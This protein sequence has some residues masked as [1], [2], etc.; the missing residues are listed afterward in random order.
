MMRKSPAEILNN[1]FGFDSFLGLQNEIID[2]VIAG[3]DAL[4][5]MPTGG[6]KSLC[7]QIPALCRDG[8]GL[9]ISPLLALM[10]DQVESLNQLGVRASVLNSTPAYGELKATEQDR[11]SVA[12]GKSVDRGGRRIMKKNREYERDAGP[13]YR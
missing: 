8:A 2:H 9:V 4:V 7:Y 3:G 13:R 1:I 12:Q 10:R 6:G 5:L 11:K